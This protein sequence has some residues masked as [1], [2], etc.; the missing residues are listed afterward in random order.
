VVEVSRLAA[1]KAGYRQKLAAAERVAGS[2]P[3]AEA[4]AAAQLPPVEA[5][6]SKQGN[7]CFL[8]RRRHNR[9]VLVRRLKM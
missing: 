5:E 9:K 7:Q 1:V 4:R 6:R 3:Q 8:I 2:R